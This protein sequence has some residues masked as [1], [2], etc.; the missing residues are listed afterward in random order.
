MRQSL[1]SNIQPNQTY[2]SID[3]KILNRLDELLE[4]G[5][6]VLATRRPPSAGHITG[7][8]VD[9]QLTN[10]WLTSCLNLIGRAFGEQSVHYLR[11]Q[12]QFP[13]YPK[14]SNAQQAFGVLQAAREDF[15]SD[16]LFSLKKLVEADVFDEFLEQAGHLLS[17]GYFQPAAVLAGAVLEDGLRVLCISKGITLAPQPKLDVMNA[18]LAKVG[19]YS[20]LQQK[21]ITA[22]A[23]IRNS[24]AHGKWTEFTAPDVEAMLRDVRAF[25]EAHYS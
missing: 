18:E 1:N 20:K 23:D 10:Q 2:M 5:K 12:A 16:S 17:S 6:K 8:F 7:D 9:V 14:W 11:L 19:T 21:R 25:M 15:A 4:L 13:D 24:A 22:L 3:E